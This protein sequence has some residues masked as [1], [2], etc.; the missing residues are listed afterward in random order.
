MQEL[1]R[2]LVE[3]LTL[4]RLDENLFRG[5]SRDVGGPNVFGGQTLGQALVAASLT[6][7]GRQAHSLHAYFLRAGDKHA[8]IDY[9][10]DRIRDGKSYTTRRVVAIQHGRPIF[11]MSASFKIAEEGVEH[12]FAMPAVPQPD[13][14]LSVKQLAAQ[15]IGKAPEKALRFLAAERPV[16]FR[17]VTPVDPITPQ[18][19]PPFREFWLRASAAL[20]DD[21]LIHKAILAYASDFSLLGTA[22]LPHALSFS[23]GSVRAASLDHAMWFHH[24]FR[25][26]DWLLYVMDSPCASNGR[27]LSRGNIFTREGQ[28][29]A[30]VAQEGM[31]RKV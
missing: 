8:P 30:S 4:V 11:N 14:L 25:M 6:V 5:D 7:A 1:V 3:H 26:D 2:E 20:P 18:A 19:R 29:V 9:E 13:G 21:P 23:N 27:G 24:D 16:E 12:Q 10:V 22:L 17:P 15:L 31:I 28:L